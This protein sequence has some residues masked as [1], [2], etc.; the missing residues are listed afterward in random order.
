MTA[1]SPESLSRSSYN[2]GRPPITKRLQL[3]SAEV[4]ATDTQHLGAHYKGT[5]VAGSWKILA[6]GIWDPL[7]LPHGPGLSVRG[8]FRVQKHR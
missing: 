8:R 7:H 6:R 4:R 5:S 3:L 1:A 2:W